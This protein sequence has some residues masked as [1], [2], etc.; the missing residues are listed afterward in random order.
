MACKHR[1]RILRGVIVGIVSQNTTDVTT[2]AGWLAGS[3]VDAV[4]RKIDEL[5]K[6]TESIKKA[7]I[8]AKKS[9]AQCLLD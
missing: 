5:E 3:D 8:A 4:L 9:L 7:L 2:V 1:V 6:E